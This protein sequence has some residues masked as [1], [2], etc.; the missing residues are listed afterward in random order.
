MRGPNVRA[1]YW[2]W[3]PSN[4]SAV[5]LCVGESWSNYG[6]TILSQ[7]SETT[8][9]EAAG[10]SPVVPPF[11]KP[12]FWIADQQARMQT[13]AIGPGSTMALVANE[14][15]NQHCKSHAENF[16]RW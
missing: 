2:Q 9:A 10:S 14:S 16:R 5:G 1:L 8:T 15:I 6:P 12:Y 3:A 13:L 7:R 11:K 4:V